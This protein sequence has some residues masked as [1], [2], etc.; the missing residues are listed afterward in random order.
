MSHDVL[1]LISHFRL[2]RPLCVVSF[3]I[4]WFS[5]LQLSTFKMSLLFYNSYPRVFVC[6][7]MNLFIGS[8]A[9]DYLHLHFLLFLVRLSISSFHLGKADGKETVLGPPN[10]N[11]LTGY[12]V[13]HSARTV[14]SEPII[15]SP[16]APAPLRGWGS[17]PHALRRRPSQRRL[18]TDGL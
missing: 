16:S 2:F 11:S 5:Q 9:F 4:S 12:H 15:A 13:P 8:V 10:L 17:G 7:F 18:S 6:P 1:D 14:G 3:S